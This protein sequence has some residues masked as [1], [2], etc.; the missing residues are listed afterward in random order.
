[1]CHDCCKV[2][3]H[4]FLLGAACSCSDRSNCS[5]YILFVC[6]SFLFGLLTGGLSLRLLPFVKQPSVTMKTKA[7]KASSAAE[8]I[9]SSIEARSFTSNELQRVAHKSVVLCFIYGICF[10]TLVGTHEQWL[11]PFQIGN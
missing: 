5:P 9:L 7:K 6:V 3:R 4:H 8:N 11:F 1:M 10:D 2:R